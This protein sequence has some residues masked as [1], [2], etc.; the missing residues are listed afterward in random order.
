MDKDVHL[1]GMFGCQREHS[2][3]FIRMVEKN[4]V[5]TGSSE[6][7]VVDLMF[8]SVKTAERRPS[9]FRQGTGKLQSLAGKTMSQTEIHA[10][11]RCFPVL[12]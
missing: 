11:D 1:P 5:L 4:P 3:Y 10:A 6:L 2:L 9:E 12:G 7:E 8:F